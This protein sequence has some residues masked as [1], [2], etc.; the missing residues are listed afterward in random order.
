MMLLAWHSTCADYS[1]GSFWHKADI[2][3]YVG[4][5]PLS[6]VKQTSWDRVPLAAYHSRNAR[7]VP[8]EMGLA[9]QMSETTL[10]EVLEQGF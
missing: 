3:A 8:S 1:D 6:G 10:T 5:C 2:P 7:D 9:I 4:L